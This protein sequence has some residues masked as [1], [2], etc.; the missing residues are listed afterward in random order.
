MLAG[1]STEI[2]AS[3]A[4]AQRYGRRPVGTGGAVDRGVDGLGRIG[5][6]AG[7]V[8]AARGHHG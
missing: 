3:G 2:T 8:T 7:G 1:L 4:V 5:D 6:V